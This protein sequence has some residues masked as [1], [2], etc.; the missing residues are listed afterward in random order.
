MKLGG[1]GFLRDGGEMGALMRAFYWSG[2]SLGPVEDW[3]D[4]LKAAVGLMLRAQAPIVMFWGPEF[5]ALYNDAYAPTIGDKHPRALGR[6]ARENWSELWSDLGPLLESVLRTG[7]PIS[8]KDRPFHMVRHGHPETVYFDISYSPVC[9]EADQVGGVFCI[10]AETTERVVAERALRESEA[11]LHGIFARTTTGVVLTDAV[12]RFVLVNA[13]LAE[14]L[15]YSEAE[16]LGMRIAEVIHPDDL[17]AHEQQ[18]ARMIAEGQGFETESRLIR[19][20]GA[21]VWASTSTGPIRDDRGDVRQASMVVMESGARRRAA[22]ME[23]RLA[24]IIESSDDAILSTDLGM[25]ITSWNQGAERLYGYTAEEAVGRPVTMLLPD[26]RMDEEVGI[27]ERICR[28][29]RIAPHETRRLR[30]D[31]RVADVSLSVAP[32]YDEQGSIIGT[33]KIARDIGARKEAERL[34]SLLMGE[35]THRVKNVL[36]T[37][38]AI[39]RQTFAGNGDLESARLAFDAR[40]MSLSNAH[41]LLTRETW[42]G[43]DLA[44]VIAKAVDPYPREHFEIGGPPVR[45]PPRVVLAMSL[46]LHELATNAAKYGALSEPEGRVAITWA[47]CDG[48]PP[49]FALHWQERGGPPVTAPAQKGFGSRLIEGVLAAELNGEVALAYEPAGLVCTVEAPLGGGWDGD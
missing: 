3:P 19:R 37:V 45:L 1:I 38:Q 46:A 22:E 9:D 10:V 31:G 33:S 30:K 15:G 47:L 44:E 18:F 11:R 27:I 35:M 17:P 5:V 20:D 12:G 32:V 42:D 13:R 49:R 41:D 23:R 29:E 48:D 34:Q 36:A 7:Q 28:G 2:T 4:C 21:T 43:A 8:A 40:I 6:P 16:L 24:A 14:I 39:A 25:V 26:D